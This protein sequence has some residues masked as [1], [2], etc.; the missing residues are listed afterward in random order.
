VSPAADPLKLKVAEAVERLADALEVLSH[1]IHD[2]PT[3]HP[4]IRISPDGVPGHSRELAEWARSPIARTGMVAAA[5][6]IALTA[7]D[8]LA[9]PAALAGAKRDFNKGHGA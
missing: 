7:V 3:I 1:R 9:A 5:N 6:A 2:T 4:S 8:L